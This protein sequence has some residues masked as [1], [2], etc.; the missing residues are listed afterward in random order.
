[1]LETRTMNDQAT[2]LRQ[3]AARQYTPPPPVYPR[4]I[5]ITS[6]KGG[7]G[8]STVSVNLAVALVPGQDV[9]LVV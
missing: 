5:A 3:A 7:V 2:R 4:V 1:M 8:K 6:G 9:A